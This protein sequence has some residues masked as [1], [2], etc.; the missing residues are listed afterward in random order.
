MAK[1]QEAIMKIIKKGRIGENNKILIGLTKG[2]EGKIKIRHVN[3]NSSVF[4]ELPDKEKLSFLNGVMENQPIRMQEAYDSLSKT[5]HHAVKEY[6]GDDDANNEEYKKGVILDEDGRE[7]LLNSD[8]SLLLD[9]DKIKKLEVKNSLGD[10]AVDRLLNKCNCVI[11]RHR[12]RVMEKLYNIHPEQIKF[13]VDISREH[14]MELIC[15]R[16]TN[17]SINALYLLKEF[18]PDAYFNCLIK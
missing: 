11:D 16:K 15:A 2:K 6:L 8:N 17:T 18:H 12:I 3:F 4:S 5:F 14:Y 10:D 1:L 9:L 13:T 7:E